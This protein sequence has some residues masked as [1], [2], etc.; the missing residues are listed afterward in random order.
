MSTSSRSFRRIVTDHN[1]RNGSFIVQDSQVPR[2]LKVSGRGVV[3][4]ETWN[5]DAS[6][7]QIGRGFV[8][9][10]GKDAVLSPPAKGT[11]FRVIDFPP[12][13]SAIRTMS[14]AQARESF[15]QFGGAHT[16]QVDAR[17]PLMHRTETIDYGIVLEGEITLVLD[18]DETVIRTGDVVIQRGTNHAWSNRSGANCRMA[19]ILIDGC[20][21]EELAHPA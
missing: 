19:F 11:R 8:E 10:V 9:P 1:E 17:H 7:V 14:A 16:V 21:D 15:A 13:D 4:H 5:T 12:E 2:I 20:F 6:P 18:E 3:F